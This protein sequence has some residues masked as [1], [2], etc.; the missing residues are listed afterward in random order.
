MLLK[1]LTKSALILLPTMLLIGCVGT[2]GNFCSVAQEI[3]Y[4]E[5]D[6]ECI[7]ASLAEGLAEHNAIYQDR[8]E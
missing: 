2:S 1:N 6:I 3:P 8:C 4:L 5:S 7:S